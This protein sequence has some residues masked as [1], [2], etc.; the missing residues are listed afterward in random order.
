MLDAQDKML[1]ALLRARDAACA[2]AARVDADASDASAAVADAA[3]AAAAAAAAGGPTM[4]TRA[5]LFRDLV[6]LRYL[7]RNGSQMH[8]HMASADVRKAIGGPGGT[9]WFTYDPKRARGQPG[10]SR[11]IFPDAS[12]FYL[13][14]AV[15]LPEEAA[16]PSCTAASCATCATYASSCVASVACLESVPPVRRRRGGRGRGRAGGA[17]GGKG[18]G[19]S[20]TDAHPPGPPPVSQVPTF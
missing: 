4:V 3:A 6:G 16:P 9:A 14:P 20:P 19:K 15:P 7:G 1:H 18:K 11:Y 12:G 5:D 13:I 17:S 10:I 8:I 2:H